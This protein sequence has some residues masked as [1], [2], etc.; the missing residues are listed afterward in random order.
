MLIEVYHWLRAHHPYWDRSGGR[1]HIILQSHDEGSCWLPAVLR[2]ATMLTH[3][4]RMDLG[5]TS[6][7][8]YIDDVYSRPAR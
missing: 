1:D 8:G 3:W 6:S 7:T 5:H 4:G 2:P